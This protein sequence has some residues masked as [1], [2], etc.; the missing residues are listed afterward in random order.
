M[1]LE[2]FAVEQAVVHYVPTAT[3]EEL[4]E[5]LLTDEAIDLDPGLRRY[6]RDKIANRLQSKGLEVIVD[7]DQSQQVPSA[8]ASALDDPAALVE[9]SRNIAVHLDAIQ[10]RVN[11]SGLLAVVSGRLEEAGCV[12]IVKLE[13][14]RGI[15]F[16]IDTVA[17][18][19]IVDL[20]LLRNLTL[21][22]K[23]K[24]YKTAL[25]TRPPGNTGTDLT[26][27]VADD[28]RGTAQGIQ[29]A[30]FF[31]SKF[32]GC[33]PKVPAAKTTFDFVKAANTSFNEDVSGPEKKGRYQ[34]AL[35]AAVQ[36]QTAEI[37]PSDFARRYL[38]SDD[39]PAFLERVREAEIEPDRPFP[40]DLSLVKLS[41]FRMTF[42][43]G[44]VLVG[45][46]DALEKRVE[47]P[48]EENSNRPVQLHDSVERLLTGR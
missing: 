36:E 11:S 7:S 44:M 5:L 47:L 22:D 28:Q 32:L 16:A 21:T 4:P 9:A 39:R 3:D 2:N 46:V 42:K 25:L 20:E 23:T 31:L 43:S 29:V 35:L 19:H 10:S 18:R 8:I 34:V 13:R 45:D 26:G 27:Y 33:K 14:E 12:A 40:K 38:D 6:F 17:G 41:G 37:V 1:D 30:S 24:V 48:S 15:R